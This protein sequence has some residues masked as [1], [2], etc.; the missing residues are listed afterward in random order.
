MVLITTTFNVV[1]NEPNYDKLVAK[2]G[3]LDGQLD[4]LEVNKSKDYKNVWEIVVTYPKNSAQEF[5][6]IIETII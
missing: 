4:D 6:A 5:G 1:G 3:G 2:F